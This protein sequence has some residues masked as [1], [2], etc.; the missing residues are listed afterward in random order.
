MYTILIQNITANHPNPNGEVEQA[1]DKIRVGENVGHPVFTTGPVVFDVN[2]EIYLQAANEITFE[3]GF[4][5]KQGALMVAYIAPCNDNPCVPDENF[6]TGGFNVTILNQDEYEFEFEVTA[7][8]GINNVEL[9]LLNPEPGQQFNI[10]L[11][12]VNNDFDN[13]GKAIVTLPVYPTTSVCGNYNI[14]VKAHFC[15][16]T[17][18]IVTF[19]WDRFGLSSV[20]GIPSLNVINNPINCTIG[21]GC[22]LEVEVSRATTSNVDLR[23]SLNNQAVQ[24]VNF[25]SSNLNEK[26]STI[27]QVFD[28]NTISPKNPASTT[29]YLLW[30]INNQC[31]IVPGTTEIDVNYVN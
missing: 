1:S 14:E 17:E 16:G 24:Y 31:N 18:E 19:N 20:F 27:I 10:T 6:L 29:I 28:L 25:N 7:Q 26:L 23:S 4:E 8:S 11:S 15:G 12:K 13:N 9:N 5:T 2:S 21:T 22:F 30:D 3:P